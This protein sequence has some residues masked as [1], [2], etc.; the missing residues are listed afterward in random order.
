MKT[1]SKKHKQS[2]RNMSK[3]SKPPSIFEILFTMP[4]YA[5]AQKTSSFL[6]YCSVYKCQPMSTIWPTVYWVNLQHN[7]VTRL[8]YVLLL[9]Y[10]GE[11]R[12]LIVITLATNVT[13][14]HCTQWKISSL[15]T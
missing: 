9:H 11:T 14:Y 8:T 4:L 2:H 15:Y 5:V 10:L 7:N 3:V 6:F 13:H 1:Q 12:E